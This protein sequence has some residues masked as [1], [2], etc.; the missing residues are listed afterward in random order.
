MAARAQRALQHLTRSDCSSAANAVS[1]ASYA[2]DHE[3]EQRSAVGPQRGPTVAAKRSTLP[4]HGFAEERPFMTVSNG[5][6]ADRHSYSD[7]RES[8]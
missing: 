6:I 8:V 1:A 2:T 3:T 7:E 5:P 4:G